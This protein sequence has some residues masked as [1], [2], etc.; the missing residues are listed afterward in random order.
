[1]GE[2]AVEVLRT[3]VEVR[4]EDAEDTP[5]G[6]ELTYRADAG[7]ELPRVVGIVVDEHAAGRIDH[8]I[9]AAVHALEGGDGLRELLEAR[10]TEVGYGQRRHGILHID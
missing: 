2:L 9:E 5:V 3:A 10:A 6:V 1:M 7:I 8:A 4:L